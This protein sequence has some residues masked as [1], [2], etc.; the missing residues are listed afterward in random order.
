M[1]HTRTVLG[2]KNS[3]QIIGLIYTTAYMF[4][5]TT[6]G[7]CVN[8]TL[9]IFCLIWYRGSNAI[10]WNVVKRGS[11]L[12]HNL[13]KSYILTTIIKLGNSSYQSDFTV[14]WNC[15]IHQYYNQNCNHICVRQNYNILYIYFLKLSV[16]RPDPMWT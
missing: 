5:Y 14:H 1:N 6:M 4:G 12:P 16:S 11:K 13:C 15:F 7:I 3:L 8:P 2:K 10:R 9:Y